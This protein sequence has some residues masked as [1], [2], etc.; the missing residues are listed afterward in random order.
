M[1]ARIGVNCS[2]NNG[3]LLLVAFIYFSVKKLFIKIQQTNKT[4]RKDQ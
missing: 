1:I 4:Q 2:E 3:I